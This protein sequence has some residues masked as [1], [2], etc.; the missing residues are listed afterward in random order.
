[1]GREIESRQRKKYF[2]RRYLFLHEREFFEQRRNFVALSRA[3]VAER[4]QEE[5]HR[6]AALAEEVV[7]AVANLKPASSK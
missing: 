6:S 4:L 3:V 5:Q 1:M 2:V 7:H